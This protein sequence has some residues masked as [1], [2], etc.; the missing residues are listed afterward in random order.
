MEGRSR[1]EKKKELNL[2]S[3]SGVDGD[4]VVFL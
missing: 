3:G 4:L 2:S 1:K